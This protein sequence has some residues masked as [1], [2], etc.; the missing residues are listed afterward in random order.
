MRITHNKQQNGN[1]RLPFLVFIPSPCGRGPGEGIRPHKVKAKRQ[2]LIA[3]FSIY[4]LSLWAEGSPQNNAC[5][6]D[7]LSLEGEGWGEGEH[8]AVEVIPFTLLSLL[9]CNNMTRERARV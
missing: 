1:L 2:S 5:T 9:L 8:M 6:E 7:S 3:V 4:S